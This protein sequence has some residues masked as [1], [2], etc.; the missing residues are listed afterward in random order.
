MDSELNSEEGSGG[1]T[2]VCSDQLFDACGA[3]PV[4]DLP[5]GGVV[6]G[7]SLALARS[8]SSASVS[9]PGQKVRQIDTLGCLFEPIEDPDSL[10]TGLENGKAMGCRRA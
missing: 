6:A 4:L 9:G 2:S 7:R 1:P 10:A 5:Q 8:R 3:E